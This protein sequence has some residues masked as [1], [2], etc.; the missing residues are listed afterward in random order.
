M[1]REKKK[2]KISR[3]REKCL[4]KKNG[5]KRERKMDKNKLKNIKK[6]S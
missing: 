6:C 5:R 3:K 2:K 4:K 1:T